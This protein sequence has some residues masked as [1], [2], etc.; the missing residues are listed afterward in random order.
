MPILLTLLAFVQSLPA[1]GQPGALPA[2]GANPS[3]VSVSGLSSGGF[4]AVQ[5]GVAWSSEVMGVGVVA[6]GPYNCAPPT[7]ASFMQVCMRGRPPAARSW[8]SARD[9]ARDGVIDPV[10]NIARQRVYLFSGTNDT[11][12][13]PSVMR[14]VHDFYKQAGVPGAALAFVATMPAGHAFVAVDI[15]EACP[16]NGGIYV[17]RCSFDGGFYDQPGAVLHHL[18]TL[19]FRPAATLSAAPLAF[20]Q[21]RYGGGGRAAMA[22]TGYAYVPAACRVT[23]AGCAVHVVFHGCR[24]SAVTIGSDA[25][26]GRLG[27]NRWADSNRIVMLYP[28]VDASLANPMGC[29]DWW[30]YTG[31]NFQLRHG[32]QIDAVHRMVSR[33]LQP[34]STPSP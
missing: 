14:A 33:L 18:Y 8:K 31:W 16:E 13:V 15:G 29:W 24:Q 19:R 17:V 1:R 2:L 3:L 32:P 21:A 5:Y 28:Q 34:E 23:G 20:D 25:I 12:V 7:G 11:V 30:G 26:Y 6:G 27:Y 22:A 9:F 4:I 10:A